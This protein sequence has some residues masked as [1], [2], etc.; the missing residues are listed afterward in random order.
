MSERGIQFEQNLI[1]WLAHSQSGRSNFNEFYSPGVLSHEGVDK[2]IE[3]LLK[4]GPGSAGARLKDRLH[5]GGIDP[6]DV[7]TAIRWAKDAPSVDDDYMLET[8]KTYMRHRCHA[9]HAEQ[10]ALASE[11]WDE[12]LIKAADAE[13][14][15]R[16]RSLTKK[17]S[18]NGFTAAGVAKAF[19]H[20]KN[21]DL[22]T[23]PGYAGKLFQRRMIRGGFVAFQAQ[24]K[25][26]KSAVM[27][28]MGVAA[29]RFG[30]RVLHISVGDQ[31][32]YEASARIISCECQRNGEPYG[33]DGYI[34]VPCCAKAMAGCLKPEYEENGYSPLNPPMLAEYLEQ[35]AV[36]DILRDFPSFKPCTLC[37]GTPD[38]SPGVWW[39]FVSD[40]PITEEEGIDLYEEIAACGEYGRV[41]TLFYPARQL[42]VEDLGEL[43]DERKRSGDP[44]DVLIVDYADM[45]GLDQQSRS[46]KWEAL[47][48]MWEAMRALAPEDVGYDCLVITG[49]QG[50]RSGGDMTTQNSTS[51]AGTRASVDNATLVIAL[52]Q[53]E[54][55]RAHHL[56]RLSVVAARKGAFAPEHQAK[57]LS[58]MDIQDPIFDSWH[59]Y[60]K[61][62]KRK[63][64]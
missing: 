53:T 62:D 42:T 46:Q 29:M 6:Q 55:E 52:N 5:A 28:R 57:C 43:L 44:V 20:E 12:K 40:E 58:R 34:G 26:G 11:V 19:S 22:F 30:H 1:G 63:E 48:Y 4:H 56:M 9:V 60:V 3:L 16:M 10:V 27:A 13:L 51:V 45:M 15:S 50:N 23:L 25:T 37:K 61:A 33:E 21:E 59:T 17:K 35:H 41:E 24:P 8:A 31:D 49:T 36:P 32:Q 39:E 18:E 38:Y 2:Y 14:Q 47:Q 7:E 54:A 64:K